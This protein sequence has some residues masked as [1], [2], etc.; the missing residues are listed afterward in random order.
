[1]ATRIVIDTVLVAN[2]TLGVNATVAALT[3]ATLETCWA[4][5]VAL[6]LDV[7]TSWPFFAMVA[8]MIAKVAKMGVAKHGAQ[9]VERLGLWAIIV[10]LSASFIAVAWGLISSVACDVI[11]ST[12]RIVILGMV[13][14]HRGV[15]VAL[16]AHRDFD[17]LCELLMYWV[18]APL[19]CGLVAL[20]GIVAYDTLI[21]ASS[22]P[23]HATC[24]GGTA[25]MVLLINRRGAAIVPSALSASYAQDEKKLAV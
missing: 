1:M 6:L 21:L 14:T 2:A 9:K 5:Q 17:R 3:A 10:L 13:L 12:S 8:L 20:G 16:F 11:P 25:V 7:Y 22:Y 24:A 4:S 18:L 23:I 15:L 19:I